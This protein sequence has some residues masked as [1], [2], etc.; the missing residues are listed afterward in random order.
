LFAAPPKVEP[1]ELEQEEE[2]ADQAI[3]N[4]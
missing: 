1:T 4:P 3:V 2:A